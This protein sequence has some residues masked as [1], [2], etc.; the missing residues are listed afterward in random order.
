QIDRAHRDWSEEQIQQITDIVR[1]YRGEKDAK[2][3]KDVKGLCKVATI[4]EIR[5]AGYSLNPGRYVGTAD[6]GTLSDEDFET[7]VRGLD[8]EFQ[9]L[10]EEA[11]DLEK[12]IA[13]NFRKL[14]I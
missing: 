14:N 1:S 12:K 5:A 11:H 7:T 4:D 9:K 2:K 13:V 3:Y 10:T 6:N 8:T